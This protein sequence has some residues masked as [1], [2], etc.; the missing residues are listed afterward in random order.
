MLARRL[1]EAD[2]VGRPAAA[3]RVGIGVETVERRD[4][5]SQRAQ[6]KPS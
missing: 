4:E 3:Q 5:E 6:E 1:F 2:V